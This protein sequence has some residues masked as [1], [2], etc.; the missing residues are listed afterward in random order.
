LDGVQKL[1][2]SITL[3]APRT[4]SGRCVHGSNHTLKVHH[5]IRR[6]PKHI[7]KPTQP[8]TVGSLCFGP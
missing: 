7:R 1:L 3:D 8:R 6:S 2:A 4:S 5:A